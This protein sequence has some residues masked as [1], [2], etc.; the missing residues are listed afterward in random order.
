MDFLAHQQL[1][2]VFP[3]DLQHHVRH[4]SHVG[5]LQVFQDFALQVQQRV[6]DNRFFDLGSNLDVFVEVLYLGQGIVVLLPSN[7]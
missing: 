7:H 3:V 6:G 2:D 5:V 1:D 4:Q